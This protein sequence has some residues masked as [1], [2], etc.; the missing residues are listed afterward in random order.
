MGTPRALCPSGS[1]EEACA[2]SVQGPHP[3]R[4]WEDPG[5]VS[6]PHLCP[7]AKEDDSPRPAGYRVRSRAARPPA[8]PASARRRRGTICRQV[9]PTSASMSLSETLGRSGERCLLRPASAPAPAAGRS[10]PGHA[11][12]AG[13]T[14]SARVRGERLGAGRFRC[15][16]TLASATRC[17][18]GGFRCSEQSPCDTL[19][20]SP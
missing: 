13:A 11:G 9:T 6:Y 4:S 7:P 15:Q 20:P 8:V 17:G 12:R 5:Q 1:T 16:E 19:S 3:H 2:L 14:V 10:P 18:R